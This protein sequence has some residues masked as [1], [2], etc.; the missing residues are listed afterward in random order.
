MRGRDHCTLQI[1]R[2]EAGRMYPLKD[3]SSA[4]ISSRVGSVVAPVEV[5]EDCMRVE[6][7]RLRGQQP[8]RRDAL[9]RLGTCCITSVVHGDANRTSR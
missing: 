7:E 2:E 6:I 5:T 4:R 3:G 1:L 9:L 8:A